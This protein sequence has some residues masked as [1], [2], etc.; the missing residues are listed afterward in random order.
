MTTSSCSTIQKQAFGNKEWCLYGYFHLLESVHLTY[1]ANRSPQFHRWFP[2]LLFYSTINKNI[3][4]KE[5][6]G[7][8]KRLMLPVILVKAGQTSPKPFNI[9]P[10]K[11][12]YFLS[13]SFNQR[14][15]IATLSCTNLNKQYS[16]AITSTNIV[17]E[18]EKSENEI[19]C[20]LSVFTAN[21]RIIM[22]SGAYIVNKI[23]HR[24]KKWSIKE[25]I[26]KV[27]LT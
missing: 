26:F 20:S 27:A 12:T 2:L 19:T 11:F 1:S 5:K 10:T 24:Y 14:C 9:N 25:M 21:E 15:T 18:Q 13:S 23:S 7:K 22:I 8:K 16:N 4:D 6:Q 3:F 17:P